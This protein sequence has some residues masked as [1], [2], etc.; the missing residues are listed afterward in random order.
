[1]LATIR[2]DG[3]PRLVPLAFAADL[4]AEPLVVYSPLDEKPKRVADPHALA[5][6]RDIAARPR[7]GLLVDRWSE[8]WRELAWLRLDGTARL[9]EPGGPDATEHARGVRLLRDRYP[10]YRQQALEQRPLVRIA[11]ERASGW[12]AAPA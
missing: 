3:R 7:V 8:D 12:R 5:R 6:V 1:V 11:V 10:Q 9:L 4:A 2:P